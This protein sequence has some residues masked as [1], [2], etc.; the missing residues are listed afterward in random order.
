MTGA[1]AAPTAASARSETA[2]ARA[3]RARSRTRIRPRTRESRV[4]GQAAR[5]GAA[6]PD[7]RSRGLRLVPAPAPFRDRRAGGLRLRDD[8][9]C[10]PLRARSACR[11]AL[12][13][14][15]DL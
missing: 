11:L 2:A 7:R 14:R 12:G 4:L 1:K 8:V 9:A 6:R 15:D 3:L 5:R 13:R 10:G